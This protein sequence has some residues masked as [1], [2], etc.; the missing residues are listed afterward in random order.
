MTSVRQASETLHG[1]RRPGRRAA[2]PASRAPGP[3]LEGREAGERGARTLWHPGAPMSAATRQ[4]PAPPSGEEERA[5]LARL[6]AG[7]RAA[8]AELVARHGGTMLHVA[9]TFVR[10][11]A[12]AEEVVQDAWL[13]LL[14]GLDRFEARASLRTWLFRILVNRARTRAVREGRSLPF[15]ALSDGGDGAPELEVTSSAFDEAGGWRE[16]PGAWSE[17]DPERL[18]MGTQTRALLEAEIARLPDA[19]RTVLTLRD[20]EGLEAEEVCVLLGISA[21]NQRVLLHR[22]RAK[23]RL[24]L[25]GYLAGSR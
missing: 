25:E 20:V 10:E 18:A 19:Q 17:E 11:R 3:T 5:V 15:S 6:R 9:M 13:G 1:T 22:A 21:S 16:P 8:F 12:T 7:D 14:D 23:V 2:G 4:P 24:A